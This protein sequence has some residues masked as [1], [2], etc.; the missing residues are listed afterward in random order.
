MDDRIKLVVDEIR[1]EEQIP[2]YIVKE[3]K[4]KLPDID[5]R[6][7]KE[8]VD[9]LTPPKLKKEKVKKVVKLQVIEQDTLVLDFLS[10]TDEEVALSLQKMSF[11]QTIDIIA[12]LRRDAY[13]KGYLAGKLLSSKIELPIYPPKK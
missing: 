10:M 7:I 13:S 12:A 11:K 8:Y 9:R 4:K 5:G 2:K 6:L 3:A 1:K